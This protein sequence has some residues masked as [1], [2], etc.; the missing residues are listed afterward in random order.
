[1]RPELK[2]VLATTAFAVV[3]STLANDRV[4]DL[5]GGRISSG[6]QLYRFAFNGQ[7]VLTF[8]ALVLY[9]ARQPKRTIYRAS[10]PAAGA[11]RFAQ[12]AGIGFGIAAAAATG[13][14]KLMGIDN[15]RAVIVG[16]PPRPVPAAQ[17]PELDEE[18]GELAIRGPFRYSRHP[19]NFAPLIPFWLT[20]HLTTRRLAMNL[21]ATAYFILGSI[22]EERRLRRA[23]GRRYEQ[24]LRSGTPFYVPLPARRARKAPSGQLAGTEEST[25]R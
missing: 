16:E 9:I 6:R 5:I 22:H 17:G 13:V 2:V 14:T 10:G 4:K 8:A 25:A 18:R 23:Y 20:P 15:V 11:L 7:A 12:I 24:Y 19:L 3:H 1:M 21:V